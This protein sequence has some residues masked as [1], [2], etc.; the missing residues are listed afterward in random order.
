MKQGDVIA[1]LDCSAPTDRV[2]EAEG[3]LKELEAERALARIRLQRTR[4]LR[5]QDA[6]SQQEL[7]EATANEDAIASAIRSQGSR[8]RSARRD[9]DHCRV[10]APF[11]GVVAERNADRGDWLAVGQPVVRLLDPDDV[12]LAAEIPASMLARAP[13]FLDPEFRTHDRRYTVEL[14]ERIGEIDPVTRT[15]EVRF[16]FPGSPPLPGTT[17]RLSWRDGDPMIPAELIV[18]REDEL[19]VML[20]R[21]GRAAFHRLEGAVAGRPAPAPE[22]AD[23]ARIIVEGR[24]AARSDQAVRPTSD[25]DAE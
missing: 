10:R 5:E 16:R 20:V 13:E 21:D 12:E 8:L 6:A 11:E 15:R 22:L 18:R 17:G 25:G 14:R 4:R 1:R 24:Q 9:M 7:D 2:E 3:R 19:G 23:D